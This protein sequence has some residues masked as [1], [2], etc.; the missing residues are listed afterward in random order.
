M[1]MQMPAYLVQPDC[2]IIVTLTET[3]HRYRKLKSLRSSEFAPNDDAQT[4][5]NFLPASASE[6]AAVSGEGA[7]MNNKKEWI[8]HFFNIT[9][10]ITYFV[11]LEGR[12]QYWNAAFG[13]LCGMSP[14][15]MK[16][17]SYIEFVCDQDKSALAAG[18]H[19]VF[20]KGL[21]ENIYRFIR[22]DEA[23]IPFHCNGTVTFN[24]QGEPNGFAGIGRDIS[25][26][27]QTEENLI[28]QKQFSDAIINSI[29]GIFFM[30]NQQGRFIRVNPQ[31][32]EVTGY[33]RD[34][35]DCLT[36]L[37]VFDGV[38]KNLIV[39]MMQQ[40]FEN[41]DSFTEARLIVKSMQKI[42]YYFTGHR[43]SIDGQSYLI[44]LGKDITERK[45][46]EVS[47]RTTASVFDNSQEA[48]LISDANNIIIDVNSAF[49]RITGYSREEMIG[50]NPR[51]LNS[52]RQDKSF[53]ASLWETLKQNRKW[54]G[55]IWNRRK[56]GEVYAEQLS[57][58]AI[59]DD[60]GTVLHYVGVFSDISHIK[61]HETELIRI[62]HYDALT[63]IPNRVLLADRMKQAISQTARAKKM[64]AVCYL[65]LDG[66]KPI[67]DT[68]GHEAGDQ[69]LIEAA[70]RIENTIRG[71]DTVARLGGDEFVLL[72]LGS[73][74]VEECV[75]TLER[76]LV[77]IAKPIIVNNKTC[78]MSASI[79]PL[80]DEDP[81]TLLRYADQAMYAAK[82]SGRNRF[83]IYDPALDMRAR[84]QYE[85]QKSI[86]QGL[87]QGQLELHYQP[88]VDLRTNEMV[89]A[90]ALIR[91]R[92]PERGL[93][94]PSEFL[95]FIEKTDLDIEIGEWVIATAL[96]QMNLWH[97]A[98]LNIEVSINISGYHLESPH[99][100]QRL[101]QQLAHYPNMPVGSLQIEVQEMIAL[102]DINIVRG[103]ISECHKFG[104]KFALDDFGTG[105]SSLS[106]LNSLPFDVLKI[107]QS[108]VRDMLEKKNDMAIVQ[109]IIALARAFNRQ[110][111]AEGIETEE[112][113][114]ALRNMGCEVGQGYVLARPMTSDM[115]ADWYAAGK[116]VSH[117]TRHGCSF[118]QVEL[119]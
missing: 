82:Q 77:T 49:T 93:L 54:R 50:K 84:N 67:N 75:A 45:R 65:D 79:Y 44:G 11:D 88:K 81:D 78:T 80:D 36:M 15:K 92:H 110:T 38:D 43:T 115:L 66:F 21:H 17:R 1:V 111:V 97:S 47:L 20:A 69:M 76:L 91:W 33:S 10:D 4:H 27:M 16:G 48:I 34:E 70:K 98:G 14:R 5:D 37:D 25:T 94:L 23:L 118:E 71:G 73:V 56:S 8:E 64:M 58:S 117:A 51:L 22:N 113:Y 31:F 39:Q 102:N 119:E 116:P 40:V 103:I 107:D 114:H 13:R 72:L 99:F 32:L 96:A 2:L 57:I 30:L 46:N 41:G 86:R 95:R 42:Q 35:L 61:E 63:G 109:G 83:H 101:Q 59:C 52:G 6:W 29:P 12:L 9:P 55:E 60:D 28:Q 112:H 19:E 108:F 3:G 104:V 89:G 62:A 18:I 106:Y 100:T 26:R 53:Y 87:K 7:R 74:H 90:E 85:F 68:L 105:Y 24:E